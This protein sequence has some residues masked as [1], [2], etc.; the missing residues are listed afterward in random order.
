MHQN[1]SRSDIGCTWHASGGLLLFACTLYSSAC[2]AL[3]VENWLHSLQ[4]GRRSG[5]VCAFRP[6]PRVNWRV[7]RFH[8]AMRS[9]TCPR[10]GVSILTTWRPASAS[11]IRGFRLSADAGWQSKAGSFLAM[12]AHRSCRMVHLCY[13]YRGYGHAASRKP[14]RTA[15]LQGGSTKRLLSRCFQNASGSFGQNLSHAVT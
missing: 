9:R 14:P 7:G 4:L 6:H 1:K 2:S 11:G 8:D 3:L 10:Q 12:A 13:G 15:A 5:P